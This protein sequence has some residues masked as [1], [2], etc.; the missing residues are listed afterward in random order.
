MD[1]YELDKIFEWLCGENTYD[2][3]VGIWL[4]KLPGEK[5]KN[6]INNEPNGEQ[7]KYYKKLEVCGLWQEAIASIF[8]RPSRCSEAEVIAKARQFLCN[9]TV[10]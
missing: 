6:T 4:H 5:V 3:E 1:A 10:T 9:V 7:R 8:Y 2:P